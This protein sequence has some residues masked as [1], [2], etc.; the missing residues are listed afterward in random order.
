ML[1][2]SFSIN[3]VQFWGDAGRGLEE[4]H[5]VLR[6]G[7]RLAVAIQPRSKGATDRTTREW[8]SR[9]Q[10]ELQAAGFRG[11]RLLT[12]RMRPASVVCALAER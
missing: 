12:R 4:L 6:P 10:G 3:A 9:L 2:R 7:G 8:G 11:V 1:F 5:R